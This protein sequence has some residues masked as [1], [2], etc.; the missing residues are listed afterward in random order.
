MELETLFQIEFLLLFIDQIP[1]L[2]FIEQ[3][4]K[5]T[6]IEQER[7]QVDKAFLTFSPWVAE[8]GVDHS[9]FDSFCWAANMVPNRPNQMP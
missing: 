1:K 9:F 8:Y 6:S 4:E 5:H 2:L 7:A 3:K